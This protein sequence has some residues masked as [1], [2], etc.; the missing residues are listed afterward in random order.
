MLQTVRPFVILNIQTIIK[1]N[2]FF[3]RDVNEIIL[4]SSPLTSLAKSVTTVRSPYR[5]KVFF[6]VLLSSVLLHAD[7]TG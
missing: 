3:P 4:D 2:M 6:L 5:K 1:N 7:S